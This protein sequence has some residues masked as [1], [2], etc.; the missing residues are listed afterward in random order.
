MGNEKEVQKLKDFIKSGSQLSENEI[1]KIAQN[2][3][4]LGLF[5]VRLRVKQHVKPPKPQNTES[6][7][8]KAGKPL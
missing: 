1:E 5:L 4:D 8:E 3:Y 6:P 2:L 7:G